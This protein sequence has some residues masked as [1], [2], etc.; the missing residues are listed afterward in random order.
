[1]ESRRLS[2]RTHEPTDLS[3]VEATG[4][5]VTLVLGMALGGAVAVALFSFLSWVACKRSLRAKNA[6]SKARQATQESGAPSPRY[7][8]L[9]TENSGLALREADLETKMLGHL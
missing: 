6:Q 8:R 4:T 5:M 9:T 7:A 1:M 2:L 3:S